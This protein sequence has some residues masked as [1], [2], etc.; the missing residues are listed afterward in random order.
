MHI[1]YVTFYSNLSDS[2]NIASEHLFSENC[3]HPTE[4]Y[5]IPFKYK[6]WIT[7]D[8]CI[9]NISFFRISLKATQ[10]YYILH[11]VFVKRTYIFAIKAILLSKMYFALSN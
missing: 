11:A 10:S 9:K 1:S 3:F 4:T 7:K 6:P 8:K 2:V 5:S